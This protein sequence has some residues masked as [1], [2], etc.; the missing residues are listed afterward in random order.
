[1]SYV[2][3][4]QTKTTEYITIEVHISI[5]KSYVSTNIVFISLF[6]PT[7]FLFVHMFQTQPFFYSV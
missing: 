3:Q 1:M 5:I 4:T 7:L 2:P 6:K